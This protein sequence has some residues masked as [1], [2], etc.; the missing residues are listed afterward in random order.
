M[1]DQSVR[2]CSHPELGSG[3][4]VRRVNEIDAL[5]MPGVA[6][7]AVDRRWR[8]ESAN[9]AA[10]DAFALR[11]GDFHVRELW[12]VS[13]RLFGPAIQG[14]LRTAMSE[15]EAT[16]VQDRTNDLSG[17]VEV[18]A[19]PTDTGLVIS[20]ADITA[21]VVRRM[22]TL[23]E[24]DDDPARGVE[25]TLELVHLS[26]LV[27]ERLSGLRRSGQI[28]GELCRLVLPRLADWSV[29]SLIDDEPSP[30]FTDAWHLDPRFRATVQCYGAEAAGTYSELSPTASAIVE[31][32][33]VRVD[34][35]AVRA[36]LPVLRSPDAVDALS[37]LSPASTV[38]VPLLIDTRLV[39]VLDLF[40]G[41]DRPPITAD[42]LTVAMSVARRAATAID[43]ARLY[44]AQTKIAGQLRKTN[45]QL[46]ELAARN[47]ATAQELQLA[48]LT[49]LPRPPGIQL[50]ARYLAANQ[51]AEVGGD[52]YDAVITPGG[53]THIVIGDVVGH[54]IA[55]AATMG[56]L[57]SLLRGFV[58]DRDE[59]PAASAERLD[60]AMRGLGMDTTATLAIATVAPLG[61]GRHNGGVAVPSDGGPIFG[62][63]RSEPGRKLRWT[64]A[65]HPAPLL[66]RPDGAVEFLGAGRDVMLGVK[67]DSER[68]DHET[69]LEVGSTLI[70]YT[71]G[72]VE[73]HRRSVEEG[74][75]QLLSIARSNRAAALDDL[76]ERILDELASGTRGDDVAVIAARIDQL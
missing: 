57:R 17:W 40:R 47:R 34:E 46:S 72:L 62:S 25:R 16:T 55:A 44:S 54:D 53:S 30:R 7:I 56:Q 39:G 33:P 76:V 70:M 35:N 23:T 8:I 64:R 20:F 15:Q 37:K 68:T 69:D 14:A 51:H 3:R 27:G 10:Q 42:E 48:L 36:L 28:A 66:V 5:G 26:A 71:D 1:P 59:G 50:A 21:D 31:R 67:P 13:A 2:G 9:P 41:E 58:W 22:R 61:R 75:A 19:R 38:S 52:W 6:V 60:R 74:Q 32:S 45:R 43:N 18:N 65:G 24:G 63:H 4:K 11:P 73:S 29:V 12:T 49:D